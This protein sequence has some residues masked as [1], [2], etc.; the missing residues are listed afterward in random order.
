M[1]MPRVR[2]ALTIIELM[3]VLAII[4]LLASLLSVAVNTV[5]ESTRRVTC[6]NNLKQIGLGLHNYMSTYQVFPRGVGTGT[7][8]PLVGILPFVGYA[9]LFQEIDFSKDLHGNLKVLRTRIPFYRCPSTLKQE[10]GIRTDYVLNRGTTLGSSRDSPW[11]L[12][13]QVYPSERWFS[14]G[15]SQTPLMSETCPKVIG[16][17]KGSS[18][19]LP[20]RYIVSNL[21]SQVFANECDSTDWNATTGSYSN[22]LY[23][24]GGGTANYYHIFGPNEKSCSNNRQIQAS[25][26][27]ATSMHSGGVNVLFADGHL[28]FMS[29]GI[30]RV[31]WVRIGKR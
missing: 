5:R 13:E 27:T 21:E 29:E 23:W 1:R 4:G 19:M 22:G 18:I 7:N 24:Y 3:V 8:G 30:D 16:T 12:E 20:Y 25:L 26:D 28:D 31:V 17:R 10:D 15:L 6:T 11:L 14:R 2:Y 9:P